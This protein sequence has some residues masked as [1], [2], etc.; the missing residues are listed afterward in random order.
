MT[1][2]ATLYSI[3]ASVAYENANTI[4][5]ALAKYNTGWKILPLLGNI[6]TSYPSGFQG[7]AYGLDSNNDGTYEEVVIAY[8]GSDSGLDWG[9]SDVQIGL[10]VTP[11]QSNAADE[12]YWL[13]RGLYGVNSGS[14]I[15]LTGHSLGGALAQLVASFEGNHAETF[16]APGMAGQA[17]VYSNIVNYVNMN[18]FI[19]SYQN[20]VGNNTLYY[21]PDGIVDGSF[22]PHSDYVDADFSKYIDLGTS[23]TYGYAL[24]LWGYDKNNNHNVQE[25]ILSGLITEANLQTAVTIVEEKLGKTGLLPCDFHYS[26]L[27]HDYI[28]GDSVGSSL[29]GSNNADKI[30]GNTGSDNINGGLGNDT[31]D[32]G[33]GNDKYVFTT[34]DGQ[35]VINDVAEL[36]ISSKGISFMNKNGSVVVDDLTL[37]GGKWDEETQSYTSL[38]TG[39]DYNWNGVNGSNLIINY[40]AGDSVTVESFSNGDLGI[41]FDRSI[42]KDPE[43]IADQLKKDKQ[44]YADKVVSGE[45]VANADYKKLAKCA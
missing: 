33:F 30:W 8:R 29:T 5:N 34:G 18:D 23:W 15:S 19:G 21:L 35:D 43:K 2:D 6:V 9:I 44:N 31:L 32:G 14:N 27:S 7:V 4:E 17:G 39:V 38:D 24:A 37:N 1:I 10:G 41:Q 11:A 13:V 40:G 25:F 26:T 3:F 36:T 28:I 12:F 22:V 42:E 16:N 20:H 45:I